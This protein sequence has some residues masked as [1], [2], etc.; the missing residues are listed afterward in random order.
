MRRVIATFV[1]IGALA[2]AAAV[3]SPAGAQMP[4]FDAARA[5]DFVQEF[6]K[7]KEQ[8]DT[9]KSQ[10][11]EAEKMYA[12]VTGERGFGDLLRDGNL[13]QYLPN[14]APGLYDGSGGGA[15]ITSS[16]QDIRRR[17]QEA[18]SGS[19][20]EAE[21]RLAE[22]SRDLAATEMAL[23]Q[24][25]FEGARK[26]LEQIEALLDEIGQT[27]D[28][29]GIAELQARLAGE[30]AAIQ[31]EFNKLQLVAQLHA[32][33]E[34]LVIEQR[35]ALSRRILNPANDGMPGLATQ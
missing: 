3:L 1:S 11:L 5:I 4:V 29:K 24:R 35:R 10:L 19:V 32:A 6:A 27:Q 12:S 28:A 15:G 7:L 17:E 20:P 31:V 13:D 21:A 23:A 2:A 30:Q 26:R 25:A 18:L 34:K 8:L 9:A 33:E 16:I 22:R 14:D